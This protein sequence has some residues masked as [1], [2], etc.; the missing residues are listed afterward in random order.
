MLTI[1]SDNSMSLTRGDSAYLTVNIKNS[2]GTDYEMTENDYLVF[3]IKRANSPTIIA[4]CEGEVA[5]NTIRIP[6]SA[7]KFNVGTYLYDIQLIHNFYD[8]ESESTEPIDY[9][10][11]TLVSGNFF[12][13]IEVGKHTDTTT[14]NPLY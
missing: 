9:D 2:D 8:E 14:I 10:V 5:S 7:T 13:T 6:T 4:R 1:F 11:F 12:L 3:S